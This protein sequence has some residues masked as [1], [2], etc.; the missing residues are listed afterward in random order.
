MY[1]VL[2]FM[3]TEYFL[4]FSRS[5]LSDAAYVCFSTLAVLFFVQAIRSRRLKDCFL[6]SLFITLALYT[7]FSGVALLG[8]LFV[9]GI[10][11]RRTL[12]RG[13]FLSAIVLPLVFFLPFTIAYLWAVGVS[14]MHVRHGPLVGIHHLKYLYYLLVFAPVPFILNVV[15]AVRERKKFLQTPL[16]LIIAAFFI[17]VGF[18]YPFFRLLYPLIPLCAVTAACAVVGFGRYK[19][20]VLVGIALSLVFSFQTITYTTNIP[21]HVASSVRNF[22]DEDNVHYIYSTSPPNVL[23]YLDGDILVPAEHPWQAMGKRIPSLLNGRT[24]MRPD[25]ILLQP[26]DAVIIVHATAVDSLKHAYPM[27]FEDA[28]VVSSFEFIDAPVYYR[29][30]Y[31]VQRNIKQLY[32]VYLFRPGE[33][34]KKLWEFG[35][36]RQTDVVFYR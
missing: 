3:T 5:G 11:H 23:Y 33:Y 16:F 17:T 9:V 29:D 13:W 21:E 36:L 26:H 2:I 27:L 18:Y 31:N 10:F 30:I 6:S 14:E 19:P 22:A 15:Q 25:S 20:A 28:A 4:F 34:T 12:H 32:E 1:G 24:V 7:K 8:I 35:F